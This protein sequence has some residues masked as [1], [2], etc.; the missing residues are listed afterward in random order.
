MQFLD[1]SFG[2]AFRFATTGKH[3]GHAFNGLTL[4]RADLV[5]MHLMPCRDLLDRLV[6]A[7]RFQRDLGL[8]LICTL[9]AFR[10]LRILPMSLDTP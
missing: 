5:R 10:L 6:T 4:P 7:Q 3:I 2:R 9:T 8:E 1:V